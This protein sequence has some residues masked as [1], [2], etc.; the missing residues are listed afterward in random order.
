MLVHTPKISNCLP[1]L[2]PQNLHSYLAITNLKI[3]A[4]Y[5]VK[6]YYFYPVFYFVKMVSLLGSEKQGRQCKVNVKVTLVQALR[7]CTGRTAR[8]GSRGTALLFHDQRH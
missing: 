1:S 6:K 4:N 5:Y 3:K 7:V 8:S 2:N